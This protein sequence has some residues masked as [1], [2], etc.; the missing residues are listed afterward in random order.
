MKRKYLVAPITILGS[1]LLTSCGLALDEVY[2][3]DEYNSVIFSENYYTIWD[4][5]IDE[6]NTKNK[7]KDVETRPLDVTGDL[8]FE[9]FYE[10]DGRTYSKNLLLASGND[11]SR[12]VYSDYDLNGIPIGNELKLSK[13]DDSFK[14]GVLS[15]LYDGQLF[16][17]GGFELV[18]VQIKESGFGQVF[19]KQGRGAEY[20]ALNFKSANDF[21]QANKPD[22]HT[23]VID[24][25]ISFYAKDDDKYNKHTFTHN[26]EVLSNAGETYSFFGFKIPSDIQNIQ[27]YSVEYDIIEDEYTNNSDPN[28]NLDHSLLLYETFLPGAT[29]H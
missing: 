14:Y 20:F 7:I 10:D 9:T 27:G 13:Q 18:R 17:G 15:K 1:L 29:W 3:S 2:R 8:V 6:N 24:L 25:K 28:K 21:K 19:D 16:C 11:I 26:M 4:S 22:A 23:T 12:Y 5:R